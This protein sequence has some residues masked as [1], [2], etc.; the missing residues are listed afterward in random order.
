[1]EKI[2]LTIREGEHVAFV[3]PSGS[4]KTTL[5]SLIVRFWDVTKG[6][7]LI[8]NVDVKDI[9]SETLMD[10]VSFVFQ[11]SKLLKTSILEN[12]R[13]GRPDASKKEVMQALREAQ[14]V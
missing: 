4:G 6:R 3:G 9:S 11:D 8:G 2:S 12:V 1:M 7:V 10:K 13:M 14:C 5:A